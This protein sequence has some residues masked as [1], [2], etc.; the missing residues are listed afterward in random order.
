MAFVETH[1]GSSFA[2]S[3]LRKGRPMSQ[4][5]RAGNPA[6]NAGNRLDLEAFAH[7]LR[8]LVGKG[9]RQNIARAGLAGLDGESAG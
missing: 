2:L 5:L 9:H 4:P 3:L 1:G 6:K 8:R 7:F